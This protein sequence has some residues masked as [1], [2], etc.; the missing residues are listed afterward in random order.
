M[1]ESLIGGVSIRATHYDCRLYYGS[2]CF[3]VLEGASGKRDERD[4]KARARDLAYNEGI[5]KVWLRRMSRERTRYNGYL[6]A[7]VAVSQLDNMV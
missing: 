7:A 2:R 4:P 3:A 6:N 5:G 1:T